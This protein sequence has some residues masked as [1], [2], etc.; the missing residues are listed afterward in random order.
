MKVL[1]KI[2]LG[3]VIVVVLLAVVGF[4]L[5]REVHME[6]SIAIDAQPNE[7]YQE[8]NDFQNFNKWS[9][10]AQIDP[11]AKYDYSGPSSGVGAKMSWTSDHPD[12]G[13]GSQEIIES[14]ANQKVT[15]VLLFDD[16]APSYASFIIEPSGNGS[17]VTW[18]FDGDMGSNPIG[19]YFGLLMDGMLGPQY[20]EGL[21]NLK[22]M[23]E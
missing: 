12:V 22:N 2:L 21:S 20:E 19:R 23:V 10:W 9:P 1:I 17:T 5:P 16:F 3:L 6:R 13:N 11:N 8:I 18:T 7:I 14:V 15:T 4:L